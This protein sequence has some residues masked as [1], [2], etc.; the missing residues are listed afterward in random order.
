MLVLS[1]K[2]NQTIRFPNLGICV[3]IVR[4]AGGKVRVGIDAP[5]DVRILRGELAD[6]LPAEPEWDV[7]RKQRHELRNQLNSVSL[8]LLLLQ[9]QLD[10]GRSDDAE[11]TLSEALQALERLDR[12]ASAD[13]TN[14]DSADS[15]S[16]ARRAL[17]VED[18][19]NERQLLAGYLQLC[20]YD[21]DAVPDGVAAMEYL[22]ESRQPDVVLLDMQM[23]RMDG[24]KTISAIRCNPAYR[25][26]KL[27]AVSGMD[28]ESMDIPL[29]EHGVD[30]WFH[31]PLTPSKFAKALDSEMAAQ[32]L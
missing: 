22:A 28:R 25:G 21:V 12:L 24:R 13:A 14:L 2:A 19:D 1:R 5:K 8:A 16:Q 4:I 6:D 23:P 20:G 7:A 17:V 31:K 10:S 18:N 9:K 15:Q 11:R 30:R 29:G 26:I 3:E 27:F 32:P